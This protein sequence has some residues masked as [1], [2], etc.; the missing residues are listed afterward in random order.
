[1]T[2]NLE[3]AGS[4]LQDRDAIEIIWNEDIIP[5]YWSELWWEIIAIELK[6]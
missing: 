2:G 6:I 4:N 1:L 5:I 3:I